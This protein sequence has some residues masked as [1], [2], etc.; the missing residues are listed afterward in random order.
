MR[1]C[2]LTLYPQIYKHTHWGRTEIDIATSLNDQSII[3]NRDRFIE[4]YHIVK[5]M[6]NLNHL[7]RISY[8]ISLLMNGHFCKF[9]E[10]GEVYKTSDNRY[11]LIVSPYKANLQHLDENEFINKC[12]FAEIAPLYSDTSSTFIK[13]VSDLTTRDIRTIL[14]Y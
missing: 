11:I 3:D 6:K 12:G 10:H 1:A 9:M 8:Y 14:L 4:N 5:C 7:K 2:E 13:D